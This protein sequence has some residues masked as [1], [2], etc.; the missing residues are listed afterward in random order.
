MQIPKNIATFNYTRFQDFFFFFIFIL[1][2]K[3]DLVKSII[4]SLCSKIQIEN[5][6]I[7]RKEEQRWYNLDFATLILVRR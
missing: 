2:N 1:Y 3:S 6:G 5:E 4:K 7:R